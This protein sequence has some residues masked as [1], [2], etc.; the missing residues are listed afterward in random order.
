MALYPASERSQPAVVAHTKWA[1]SVRIFH[2]LGAL[3]LLITWAMIKLDA[4]AID[5]TYIDL[6]KAFGLSVLFWTVARLLNRVLT[7]KSIPAKVVMPKWQ[8]GIVHLTQL[9]LYVCMLAMPLTAFTA[10][11]MKG[12]VVWF[13]GMEIPAF[14]G[15]NRDV[16]RTLM[17]LHK[18]VFWTMLLAFTGLHILGALQHQFIKKDNLIKR[19]L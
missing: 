15:E 2:W 19:M 5:D 8:T 7:L 1:I 10:E 17:K 14:I 6:H 12:N 13:F 3:L 9:L 16:A 18:D 11:M 4:N